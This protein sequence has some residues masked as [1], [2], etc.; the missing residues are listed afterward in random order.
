MGPLRGLLLVLA[1]SWSGDEVLRIPDA[2]SIIGAGA[3]C[4]CVARSARPGAD[5]EGL[6]DWTPRAG[7]PGRGFSLDFKDA[8]Q[9]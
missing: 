3:E 4:G 1:T 6:A 7:A 5:R 9:V 2:C 8:L